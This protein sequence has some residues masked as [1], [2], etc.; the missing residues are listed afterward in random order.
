MVATRRPDLIARTL[1]SFSKNVFANF[2][3]QAF[4]L[5]LDPAFGTVADETLCVD[6]VRQHFP[7]A[8]ITIPDAPGFGAAVKRLWAGAHDGLML[9]LEDDW[10]VNEPITPATVNRLV[11]EGYSAVAPLSRYHP[12][13]PGIDYICKIKKK[14]ILGIPMRT[15]VIPKL[16]TSPKFIL[17]SYARAVAGMLDPALDPEKQMTNRLNPELEDFIARRKCHLLR[18]AAGGPLIEDIGRDWRDARKIEK[19]VVDGRSIWKDAE[20]APDGR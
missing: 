16:G 5:N 9:H 19:V 17:G 3:V 18:T 4:R 8:D 20:E 6:I 7:K 1:E 2:D 11:A 13:H 12:V 10:L 15:T 14:R